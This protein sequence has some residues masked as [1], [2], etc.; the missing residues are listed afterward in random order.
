[1]NSWIVGVDLRHRSDG[2]VR[3]GAW[4]RAQTGGAIELVGVHVA[5]TDVVDQLDQFEGRVRVRERL[6][7]EAE[8]AMD[9]A[10][11]RD[12]YAEVELIEA[13]E[14]A[15]A[16]AN[17]RAGRTAVGLIVGR[18]AASDGRDLV[19]LGS[20]ARR[21]LQRLVV[22]T[23]V[24]PPDLA[25]DQLGSGPIVV[26]VTPADASAGAVEV[27]AAMA[28]ALGRP[29]VFVRVVS[30]PEEYTQIYWSTDALAQFKGQTIAAAKDRSAE[31][32]ADHGRSE[33]VVVRYGDTITE[34][35]AVAAEQGAPFLVCGSRLL[36][37]VERVIALSTS[38]ELAARAAIPVL[39]VPPDARA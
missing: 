4:L 34:I 27:G 9:R 16:L 20:V 12:A 19:R 33:P 26:A 14:P 25:A 38:S 18:K 22:P 6:K 23:F 11:V 21:L 28:R 3:F 13:D 15:E 29:L 2:A 30:V 7:T 24:V 35:L 17:A 32:L 1:M 36:S 39:V 37:R 31:W 5:P 10:G 8:L